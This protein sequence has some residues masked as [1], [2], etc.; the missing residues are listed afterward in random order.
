MYNVSKFEIIKQQLSDLQSEILSLDTEGKQVPELIEKTNLLREN[1]LLKK[2]TEK[3]SLLIDFYLS[4]T[5]ILED[6][7]SKSTTSK[8][9]TVKRSKNK[10]KPKT[11]SLSKRKSSKKSN[12]KRRLIKHKTKKKRKTRK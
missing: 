8:L 9:K 4:Y 10:N 6:A 3:K 5:E 7:L 11:R 2:L 1:E 12:Y